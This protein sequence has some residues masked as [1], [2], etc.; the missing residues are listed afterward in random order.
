MSKD[1]G[2]VGPDS[3]PRWGRAGE[4]SR[5]V[6]SLAEEAFG[7]TGVA[8]NDEQE[9]NPLAFPVYGPE[10]I[11]ILPSDPDAGLIDPS[12]SASD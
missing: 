2:R 5:L 1:R 12:P 7:G 11:L 8:P 3:C 9:V 6:Q 4:D 10:E